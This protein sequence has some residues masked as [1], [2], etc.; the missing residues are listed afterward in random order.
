MTSVEKVEQALD[1]TRILVLGTQ[2]LVS[3]AFLAPFQVGFDSLPKISRYVMLIGLYLL[4]MTLSA[5][6]MPILL[7]STN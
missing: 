3:F 5:L 6:L 7:S 4:L 1:E 2:V